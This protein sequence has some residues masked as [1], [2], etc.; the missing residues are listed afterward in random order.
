MKID[1]KALGQWIQD[2]N[3]NTIS[4]KDYTELW[5]AIREICSFSL[6]KYHMDQMY[7]DFILDMVTFIF[8][9]YLK[10]FKP[11]S[12]DGRSY[13]ALAFLLQSAYYTKHI[14]WNTSYQFMLKELGEYQVF[15][16]SDENDPNNKSFLDTITA[17]DIYH[18]SMSI[19]RSH[20]LKGK[21]GGDGERLNSFKWMLS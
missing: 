14:L 19:S 6:K 12:E 8:N 11:T 9:Q 3:H 15:S 5:Y 2:Y 20:A 10:N 13:S 18:W 17:E 1:N 16:A 4:E 7:Y 21:Y